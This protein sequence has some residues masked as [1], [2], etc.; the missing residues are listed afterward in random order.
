MNPLLYKAHPLLYLTV[1]LLANPGS[2]SLHEA[3]RLVL[4][5]L[6]VN[7]VWT[8]CLWLGSKKLLGFAP[9]YPLA[10]ALALV[11][12][13]FYLPTALTLMSDVLAREFRFQDRFI[14]VFCIFIAAQMLGVFY[15]VAI[16]Y[17]RNGR[18]IG[19]HDGMAISLA[20]WLASLPVSLALLGLNAAMKFI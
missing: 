8:P 13:V 4:I 12:L 14:L 10:Y 18:A 16:R 20:L 9:S 15:A 7:L 5:Y 19:L 1:D 11:S 3:F 2:H 17:P 6:C